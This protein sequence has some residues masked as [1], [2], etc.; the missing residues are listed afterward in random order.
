[1]SWYNFFYVEGIEGV[2]SAAIGMHL[3]SGVFFGTISGYKAH[4]EWWFDRI[5][6]EGQHRLDWKRYP[7]GLPDDPDGEHAERRALIRQL[8]VYRR[9]MNK[10]LGKPADPQERMLVPLIIRPHK[11][12]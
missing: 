11:R 7:R 6:H 8:E 4:P 2:G 3:S 5:P 12:L 10:P 9:V 1:V